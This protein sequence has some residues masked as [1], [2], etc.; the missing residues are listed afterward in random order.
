MKK[1]ICAFTAFALCLSFCVQVAAQTFKD[2]SATLNLPADYVEI[3]ADNAAKFEEGLERIGHTKQSFISYLNKNN[4]LL[5]AVLP[6][7]SRQIQF[8]WE[9]TE[10][11]KEIVDI[12]DAKDKSFES[13]GK[14]II[15]DNSFDSWNIIDF[16]GVKYFEAVFSSKDDKGS[17]SIQ[18]IT[19][20]NGYL[21]TLSVYGDRQAADEQLKGDATEVLKGLK[22]EKANETVTAQEADRILE[23]VLTLAFIA[24]AAVGAVLICISFVKDYKN[25]RFLE[26]EGEEDTIKRRKYR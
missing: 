10:F 25:Q 19:I 6:D 11:S 4:V 2:Y 23:I 16:D 13:I 14:K 5:F 3:N 17:A 8:K 18:Y 9:Q 21:F 12:S 20:R 15:S 7:N 24:V 26:S 1:I 22:I